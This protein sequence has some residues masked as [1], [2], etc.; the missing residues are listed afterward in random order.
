MA[1]DVLVD[2][3][4]AVQI[5]VVLV[6]LLVV[7]QDALAVAIVIV[8]VVTDVLVVALDVRA[9]VRVV[10]LILVG[11]VALDVVDV[12]RL[13]EQIV[14]L[15]VL[16]VVL[17]VLVVLVPVAVAAKVNV[18]LLVVDVKAALV[19]VHMDVNQGVKVVQDAADRVVPIVQEDVLVDVLTTVGDVLDAE[20]AL[21]DVV[22]VVRQDA[23]VVPGVLDAH[24]HAMV[25]VEVVIVVVRER[26]GHLVML[27]ARVAMVVQIPAL[28]VEIAVQKVV[29]VFA[30]VVQ[31]VAKDALTHVREIA[32]LHVR[33]HAQDVLDVQIVVQLHAQAVPVAQV[34]VL[35]D[36]MDAR[37]D[38]E[39]L[40][41]I[42]VLDALDVQQV[43]ALVVLDVMDVQQLVQ[44]DVL[45]AQAIAEEV[46]LVIVQQD[47]KIVARQHV[48]QLAIL[49]VLELVMVLV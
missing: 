18:R 29:P 36:A 19:R 17:V 12:V 35:A 20:H 2:A 4:A 34:H 15:L 10:V 30:L 24:H 47:V 3:R 32:K 42:H 39:R 41:L 16:I 45:D 33:L 14:R 21:V 27:D 8:P 49:I 23:I 38:V 13:V 6:V 26:A 37:Q 44:A 48:Q 11:Q 31:A 9:D 5:L 46:V 25:D 1:L 22:A 43:V 28:D 40:V 7:L